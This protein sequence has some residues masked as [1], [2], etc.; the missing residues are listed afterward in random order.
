MVTYLLITVNHIPAK[1]YTIDLIILLYYYYNSIIKSMGYT[2]LE[3][4]AH[5]SRTYPV[6]DVMLSWETS[7][8][9][10]VKFYLV[11]QGEL[12]SVVIVAWLKSKIR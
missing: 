12:Q 7:T 5:N 11:F 6:Y 8:M 1:G 10:A 2:Y 4:R 9:R 3:A